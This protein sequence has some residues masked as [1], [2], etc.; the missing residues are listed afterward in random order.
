MFVGQWEYEQI[1]SV[2][3]LLFVVQELEK[4]VASWLM[5]N[6]I[7]E[8]IYIQCENNEGMK[9]ALTTGVPRREPNY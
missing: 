8:S 4:G 6:A 9:G 1:F 5:A 7:A 3:Y 2:F